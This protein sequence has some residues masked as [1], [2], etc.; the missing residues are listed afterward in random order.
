MTQ[1]LGE[2][3]ERLRQAL[4]DLG[5]VAVAFSGGVDSA[6]LLKTARDVLG[7]EVLALTARSPLAPSR[8]LEDASRLA[9]ETG[10]VH[11]VVDLNPLEFAD[12]VRNGPDRCYVCKKRLMGELRRVAAARG[13]DR[14]LDGENAD[15]DRDYR[16]GAR[17]VR[18]LGIR[19]PLRE[20]GLGK[21]DIRTLSRELGLS[22]WD[23]P[24]CAC[25]ASR[26]PYGS[27]VSREKLEQI[28]RAEAFLLESGVAGQ[29]RVR[30]HGELARIETGREDLARLVE[31]PLRRRIVEHFESLGFLFVALDLQ[32]YSTGSMNRGLET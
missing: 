23:K 3:F 16:P 26:I 2:K 29:V 10:A 8:E 19:S 25:L 17:A 18:E 15:D 22:T 4:G 14:L 11:C 12:F 31:D 24:S 6:F 5:R 20:A 7:D 1:E 27:P 9:R 21:E 28:D 30:H 32:G 13:F